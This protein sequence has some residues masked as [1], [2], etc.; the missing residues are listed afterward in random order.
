MKSS[1]KSQ[2]RREFI[3]RAA[4]LGLAGSMGAGQLLSSCNRS[5]TRSAAPVFPEIA[6]DGPVLKAG[7]I[8]CG[9]RGTGAA[10]N[11]L[12]AGPNLEITALAD[13]F[14]DRI[15]SCR[16]VLKR[17]YDVEIPDQNCFVGFDAY[18]RVIDSGVDVVLE[19]AASHFRPRHFEAAV[20]ARKHVF[21]EKPAGVDPVGVRSVM[22]TGRMAEAAGLCVIAGFQRRHQHDHVSTYS[23]IKNGAIGDLVSAVCSYNRHGA[24]PFRRQD[25]WCDMEAMLRNRANWNWLTGDSIVNLLIHNIDNIIWFFGKHPVRATGFGGRHHRPSGD[26][27]DFFSVDYIFDDEKRIHGMCR[28][29]DGCSNYVGQTLFGTGGY[30]NCENTIWDNGGN[31]IW[32]YKYPLDEDGRSLGRVLIPGHDQEIINLVTAIRTNNPVNEAGALAIST[33]VT[34]MGRESAYTGQDVTWDEIMNSNHR[35]GP[36]E[37]LMGPVKGIEPVAPVPGR[38]PSSA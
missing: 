7:L 34:I 6:P 4:L 37:Y 20:Q 28:E 5:G 9:G 32:E 33:L 2:S 24:L 26:M 17:R 31:V 38:P 1:K 35:L 11:F 19:A 27:Y 30:T 36:A 12:R 14:P 22:A 16:D 15:Q 10:V 25:G 29:I 21:L 13:V 8:G 18:Q 3:E 23:M